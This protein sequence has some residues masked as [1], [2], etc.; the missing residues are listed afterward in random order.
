MIRNFLR[1]PAS[2][3]A[4]VADLIRVVGVVSIVVALVWFDLTDAGVLAFTLPGL[5]LPRFIGARPWF[6][7]TCQVTLLVAAWSNVFDLYTRIEWWDLLIHFLCTGVVAAMTYLLLADVKIVPAPG[8][9]NF[10]V[11]TGMVITAA[12][13]LALSAIWEMVE[14]LGHT[15]I[16]SKIFV[17]YDDTI[18]DMAVGAVGAICAGLA[19]AFLPLARQDHQHAEKSMPR[20]GDAAIGRH[21]P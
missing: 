11:T 17:A 14:W 12:F 16:S 8:E 20:N 3:A 1:A 7:I 5:L 2:P 10:T 4:L 6:D 13:G 15:F 18:A 21:R 9:P 19:I